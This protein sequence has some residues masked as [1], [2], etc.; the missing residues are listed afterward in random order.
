ME[1]H[2]EYY[3]SYSMF[4]KVRST[5]FESQIQYEEF[6]L[7]F[8]E[9]IDW[10]KLIDIQVGGIVDEF[11]NIDYLIHDNFDPLQYIK[12]EGLKK[13]NNYNDVYIMNIQTLNLL[14]TF[15]TTYISKDQN[16]LKKNTSTRFLDFGSGDP[17]CI[18]YMLPGFIIVDKKNFEKVIKRVKREC[19]S[20]HTK[21][22]FEKYMSL[23]KIEVKQI[24]L[25]SDI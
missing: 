6:L 24:K 13:L 12:E 21:H 10:A 1:K 18:D 3:C 4:G 22:L 9:K 15:I 14:D 16:F 5:F 23:K 19:K 2:P 20:E 17:S 25:T 7:I 11:T 8:K